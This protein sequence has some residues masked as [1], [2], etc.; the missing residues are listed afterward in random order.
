MGIK[1]ETWELQYE[2]HAAAN[3]SQRA[4]LATA[5]DITA[6]SEGSSDWV[7]SDW[8]GVRRRSSWRLLQKGGKHRTSHVTTLSPN[9]H[10]ARRRILDRVEENRVNREKF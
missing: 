6:N 2:R 9:L 10:E 4:V 7:A 1:G 8:G 5:E 3:E